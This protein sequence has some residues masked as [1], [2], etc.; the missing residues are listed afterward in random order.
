MAATTAQSTTGKAP[1]AKRGIADRIKAWAGDHLRFVFALLRCLKPILVLKDLAVITRF[2]DVQEVLTRDEEFAVTYAEKMTIV[3]DGSNFFLGMG[4][5]PQ[6]TQDVSNMRLAVRRT[7]VDTLVAPMVDRFATAI[8]EQSHG[9]LDAVGELTRIVPAML[10]EQYMGLPGP[11]RNE[12]IQWTTNLFYYLFFP[13]ISPE[14]DQLAVQNAAAA[15]KHIDQLIAERKQSG[16]Q[17]DDVLG[18]LLEMQPADLPGLSDRDIRN[19]LLGIIIGAIPTTSKSAALVLDYLLD[20]PDTLAQAKQVAQRGDVKTLNKYVLESLRFNPFSPGIFRQCVADYVVAKGTFRGK[21]IRKGTKVFASTLSAMWDG[22]ELT[23]PKR[24][25]VTRP[26]YQYMHYGYGMHTCFGLYINHVQI[27]T[28]LKA[29]L[30]KDNLQ[31]APGDAG[32]LQWDGQFPSHLN[33][34]FTP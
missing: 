15:R 26:D 27:A 24:F 3:G 33:V 1:P 7:D 6:Y 2:E 22:R 5:T 21:R 28:I 8:V 29:L 10:V 34:T 13:N 17:K 18:R 4:P 14:E 31:R 20:H 30:I 11:T 25:D 12:L 23:R 19:N 16:L 9:K 32:K